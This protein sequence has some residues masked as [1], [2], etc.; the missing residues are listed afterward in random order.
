MTQIPTTPLQPKPAYPKEKVQQ[1]HYPQYPG[2]EIPERLI[3]DALARNIEII[4]KGLKLAGRQVHLPGVGRI[5]ILAYDQQGTPVIIEVKRGT[6]DNSTL[7]QLL[8]YMSRI[9]EIESKRTRGI[10]VAENFTR[11]LTQAAKPP[12]NIKLIKIITKNHKSEIKEA[13]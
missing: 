12:S 10:I 13:T 7:T 3:E 9:E 2:S 1:E 4:E 5:D 11:K 6:A 8:A